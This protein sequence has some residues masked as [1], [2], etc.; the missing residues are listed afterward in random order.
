MTMAR[1]Q[2]VGGAIVTGASGT[3]GSAIVRHL[4]AAGMRVAA[5]DLRDPGDAFA[6][7]PADAVVAVMADLASAEGRAA[8]VAQAR[9]AVGPVRCLVNDAADCTAIPLLDSDD[10]HWR[11]I[12][13]TNVVAPAAL[14][15]L[16]F[17]D[18]RT[19]GGVVVNMSSVRGL[20]CLPGGAAYEA[21]KAAL[22]GLTRTIA[23]ELGHHGI[24]AATVCPGAIAADPDTWLDE[25]P[26]PYG[27]AWT[28]AHPQGRAG[29]PD[30]VA[31]VVA[32]LCSPAGAHVNGTEIVVDG[33][34][35]AQ[36]PSTVALRLAGQLPL[37]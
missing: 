17:E 2:V 15:R 12:F 4:V 34:V 23:G 18:L 3:I 26:A 7:L 11:S 13:E 37:P 20:A 10:E 19:T 14:V 31:A 24:R 30:S 22:L 8:A 16:L 33:G 28:A 5:V 32:F 25:L 36:Y 1:E 6:D 9:A 29:S 21:S 35:A 27:E